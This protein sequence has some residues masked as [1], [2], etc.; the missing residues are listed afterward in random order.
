MKKSL[1]ERTN[2]WKPFIDEASGAVRAHDYRKETIERILHIIDPDLSMWPGSFGN[3]AK[4]IVIGSGF[5]SGRTYL[6]KIPFQ[7]FLSKNKSAFTN[8]PLQAIQEFNRLVE[9]LFPK[10]VAETLTVSE[11]MSRR[12]LSQTEQILLKGEQASGNIIRR[13]KAQKDQIRTKE[14]P[15]EITT[16]SEAAPQKPASIFSQRSPLS[17]ETQDLIE[18]ILSHPPT[19]HDRRVIALLEQGLEKSSL[20]RQNFFITLTSPKFFTFKDLVD[21]AKEIP[22]T[23]FDKAF[24]TKVFAEP[25][26]EK[27]AS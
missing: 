14:V 27:T 7:L 23:S 15:T 2:S 20:K 11:S 12:Y 18:R 9:A 5:P 17:K 16:P 8:A 19:E 3:Y 21:R 26:L 13:L 4:G 6:Y 24:L 25:D 22:S 10:P 1:L